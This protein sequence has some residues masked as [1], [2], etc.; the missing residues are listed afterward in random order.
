MEKCS[1]SVNDVNIEKVKDTVLE[2]RR[3]GIRAIAEDLTIFYGSTQY[4][5][6]NVFGMK[7]VKVFG[8]KDLNAPSHSSMVLTNFVA[9][10]LTRIIA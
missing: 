6:V 8:T 5:L 3:V 7:R 4:N 9:K 2:N 1:I 10:P